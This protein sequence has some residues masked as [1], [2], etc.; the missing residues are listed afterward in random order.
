M[1]IERERVD[2]GKVSARALIGIGVY[3]NYLLNYKFNQLLLLL[4]KA[5]KLGVIDC[6]LSIL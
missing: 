2:P 3:G 5:T 4:E 1:A 6:D